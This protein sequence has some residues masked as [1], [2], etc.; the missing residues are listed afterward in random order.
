MLVTQSC[1]TLRP[2]GL[3]PAR[4]LY[5]WNSP[6]KN[7]GVGSHSFLQ[8]IFLTQ[9]SNLGFCHIASRFFTI[10]ATREAVGCDPIG[11]VKSVQQLT[12]FINENE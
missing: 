12:S 10:W 8:G 7:T 3:Q 1:L 4:V 6:G 2:H 9:G 5:S 11:T